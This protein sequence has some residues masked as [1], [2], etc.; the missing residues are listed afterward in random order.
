MTLR[1]EVGLYLSG[2]Q[3]RAGRAD[4]QLRG[5]PIRRWQRHANGSGQADVPKRGDSPA[6]FRSVSGS[7]RYNHE[8]IF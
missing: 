3:V 4:G 5:P 2:H 6:P 8:G 1:C 7:F